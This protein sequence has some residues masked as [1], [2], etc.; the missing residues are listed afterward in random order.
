MSTYK[1][2]RFYER[3]HPREV[4]KTGLTLNEA[5]DHCRDPETSS[6]TAK[7]PEAVEHTRQ[8]GVWFD[9]WREE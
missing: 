4:I 2:V 7:A 8:M 6:S 3:E 9:G 1:V 5:Q